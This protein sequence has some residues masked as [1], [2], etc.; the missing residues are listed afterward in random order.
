MQSTSSVQGGIQL[1][2]TSKIEQTGVPTGCVYVPAGAQDAEPH[3]VTANDQYKL[4][5]IAPGPKSIQRTVVG[6]T[7]GG[8][9]T[10]MLLLSP[11]ESPQPG[12]PRYLAYATHDKVV[13]LVQMPLDGNPN[14]TMG[15]IAH[16]GEVG[17][18]MLMT[19]D[20]LPHHRAPRGGG[21]ARLRGSLA[22]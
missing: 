4:R 13:G 18:C 9:L 3:V 1:R 2:N 22:S 20:C 11:G 7:Y 15:L 5:V 8:P 16:P 10:R 12:A 6:P 19:S 14:K 21:R 17:D